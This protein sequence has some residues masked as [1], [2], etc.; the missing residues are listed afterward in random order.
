M[1]VPSTAPAGVDENPPTGSGYSPSGANRQF[2]GNPVPT[3]PAAPKPV[4]P[5]APMRIEHVVSRVASTSGATVQGQIVANNYVTPMRGAK[6]VFVSKQSGGPQQTAQADLT[7][8][9]N[10]VLAAGGWNI[11]V[12]RPDGSLEYHSNIDVYGQGETRN[13]LVVSR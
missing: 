11:Y 5:G 9:F 3:V 10:V 2:L 8:R 7:G 1:N 4:L 12:G 13:V 6:L